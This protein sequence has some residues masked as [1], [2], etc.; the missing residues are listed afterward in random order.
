MKV[1]RK[2]I[3]LSVIIT[4]HSESTLTGCPVEFTK[5]VDFKILVDF[6]IIAN[7]ALYLEAFGS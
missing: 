3:Y 2:L 1:S 5:K 7:S 6:V 4:H